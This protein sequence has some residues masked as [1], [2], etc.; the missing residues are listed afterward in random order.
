[1]VTIKKP[2]EIA[3]LRQG[4]KILAEVLAEL[5]LM[6]KPGVKTIEL[7]QKAEELIIQ[8]GGVPAF[9]NYSGEYLDEIPF[10]TTICASIN[11]QLVHA[12]AG[13]EKLKAGD[14]LS[15]DIGMK[16]PAVD[17]YFTDMSTTVAIGK[18]PPAT[19]R[20]LKVTKQSLQ[21]GIDQVKEGNK[22]SDISK[23]IQK[24]V[25][26]N[27]FSIVRQLVGHGVGYKVHEDPK[28]PNYYDPRMKD[29]ELKEGMVLAIEP[30]V[31]VGNPAIRTLAD[32]WTIATADGELCAH[33]EHTIVVTKNGYGIL[34]KV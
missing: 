32:G 19:R 22:I 34:T 28:I 4:G 18:I 26:A 6:A 7:D 9:K 15:I 1:M 24:Y 25:E 14:I 11:D 13:P 30:M 17:G 5:V 29:I 33:F 3:V 31:N 12:P 10:P 27:G 23:A 21:I 20:L 8:R 16:Y 2:Q